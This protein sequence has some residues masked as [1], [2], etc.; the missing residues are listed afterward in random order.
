MPSTRFGHEFHFDLRV[1]AMKFGILS[2]ISHPLLPLLFQ[3]LRRS[4]FREFFV[5]LDKKDFSEKNK[6]IWLRRT[7]G[8]LDSSLSL[9]DFCEAK[10]PFYFVSDHNSDHCL[11]LMQSIGPHFLINGGTPRKMSQALLNATLQGVINVHPGLLPKYRGSSCVEWSILNGDPV[12]N[13]AHFMTSE[14]D[15]GPVLAYETYPVSESDSYQTI[16]NKVYAGWSGL[17][18]RAISAALMGRSVSD[19][20]DYKKSD[21]VFPPIPEEKMDLVFDLISSGKYAKLLDQKSK[22]GYFSTFAW[23]Y[24]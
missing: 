15:D 6:E 8:M 11:S 22:A 17:M 20:V 1:V 4:G 18:L 2:C 19:C 5:V 7:G 24:D 16:R 9:Y 12:G 14:Y 23:G 21:Y 13:T 10:I 3:E